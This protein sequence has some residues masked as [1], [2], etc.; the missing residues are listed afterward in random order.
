MWRRW[1][2]LE[3][4][5]ARRLT[6]HCQID[7]RERLLPERVLGA[8]TPVLPRHLLVLRHLESRLLVLEPRHL[9]LLVCRVGRAQLNLVHTRVVGCLEGDDRVIERARVDCVERVGVLFEPP[10]VVIH[11]A[12]LGLGLGL[13]GRRGVTGEV[14]GDLRLREL[15]ARVCLV[16]LV[17]C[18]LARLG[19]ELLFELLVRLGLL[20]GLLLLLG[21]LGCLLGVGLLRAVLP[22]GGL[23]VGSLLGLD[24]RLL[25]V[26]DRLLRDVAVLRH[27][28]ARWVEAGRT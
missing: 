11:H 20:V 25:F 24:Q 7:S 4:S 6:G 9:R 15:E 13:R 28:A 5:S 23:G 3:S 26:L 21:G 12:A 1:R 16:G 18:H 14:L 2:P 17:A 19:R 22:V 8:L 27:D 10:H